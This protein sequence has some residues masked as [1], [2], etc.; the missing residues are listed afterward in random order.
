MSDARHLFSLDTAPPQT[1]NTIVSINCQGPVRRRLMDM[2]LTPGTQVAVEGAAPLGD[3][4][5]VWARGCRLALRCGEAAQITVAPTM[6]ITESSK[7]LESCSSGRKHRHRQGQ[8]GG[9][10]RRRRQR[11]NRGS[12]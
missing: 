5:I 11:G 7:W 6:D 3:P 4:I 9:G 1:Q 10:R 12:M 8:R 2:G